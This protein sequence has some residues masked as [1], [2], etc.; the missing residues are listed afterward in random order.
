M[1]QFQKK[2]LFFS[3]IFFRIVA[4]EVTLLPQILQEYEQALQKLLMVQQKESG[5]HNQD[6]LSD[7]LILSTYKKL[8]MP[9][10]MWINGYARIV[11]SEMAYEFPYYQ[12]LNTLTLEY[13][14]HKTEVEKIIALLPAASQQQALDIFH[15][16][17]NNIVVQ[18]CFNIVQRLA[19]QNSVDDD[20]LQAAY[21]AYSLAW[22]I[23]TKKVKIEGAASFEEFE[24][25]MMSNMQTLFSSAIT[26]AQTLLSS[27]MS[28]GILVEPL[29]KKLQVCYQYLYQIYVQDG[30]ASNA[31]NQK[32]LLAALKAQEQSYAQAQKQQQQAAA[33]LQ[34]AYNPIV[35]DVNNV[36]TV[37]TSVADSITKLKSALLLY[38]AA[39]ESFTQ[40]NDI[41]GKSE[42]ERLQQRIGSGDMLLRAVQKLWG[43][44]LQDQSET[45]GV[46]T[47]PTLA[48]FVAG[49]ASGQ[50]VNA[51]QALQNLVGMC[52]DQYGDTNNVGPLFSSSYNALI[53]PILKNVS[54]FVEQNP[55]LTQ[56]IDSL[57]DFALIQDTQ[58]A[59]QVLLNLCNDMIQAS[60]ASDQT[61]IARAMSYAQLLDSLFIKND[62]LRQYV[63]YLPDSL[64]TG[65]KTWVNFT[66]QFFYQAGL[67]GSV[68][69]A[70]AMIGKVK[71]T[72]PVQLTAKDLE[73]MQN[74]ADNL[75]SQAEA[76]EK[77]ENFAS[78]SIAYE[79][80]MQLY[81]KLY[82]HE[83]DGMV[84]VKILTLANVAKTRFA[85][86]NFASVIQTDGSVTLG[87]L[88]NIPTSYR[89]KSY[90]FSFNPELTGGI[91]PA[92]L[93]NL[94]VG[95]TLTH[96][97][98]LDQADVFAFVKAT[99]V[100]QKLT[101]QGVLVEGGATFTDYFADYTMSKVVQASSRALTAQ[102]QIVKY[103]DNF[104]GM[105][106]NSVTLD[107]ANQVLINITNF[108]LEALTAPCTTLSSAGTYYAAASAL[109]A[110]GTVPLNLG[111]QTYDPGNDVLSANLML[112]NLGYV[113][114]S[115]AQALNVQ[116]LNLIQ[117]LS[118]ELG[119]TVKG[120]TVKTLPKDFT[121]KFASIQNTA[122]LMQ[123]LLY[124]TNAASGFFTQA[125]LISL[126]RK[127]K[128]EF[129]NVYKKQIDFSKNC[130]IGNPTSNEYQSIVTA[131]NRAYVSWA[132]ALDGSKDVSL[133]ANINTKI[134]ELYEF[135]G[136]QCLNYSYIEPEFPHFPQIHYMVAAQYYKSALLQYQ[137]LQ[138]ASK[139]E[140]LTKQVNGM[141]YQGCVQNLNLYLTV[142]K[143]GA[144]YKKTLTNS[145]VLITFDQ[146]ISD[147][148]DGSIGT[149]GET[150]LY[151]KIQDLLLD[152]A[153]VLD[154]LADNAGSLKK[155]TNIDS[156]T[157]VTKYQNANHKV[158]L[159]FL[160][161]QKLINSSKVQFFSQIP[162][163]VTEKIIKL[164]T[165][166]YTQF[167]SEP[168]I[169]AAW[170]NLLFMMVKNMYNMDYQAVNE[171]STSSQINLATQQ[172]LSSISNEAANLQNPS[173]GYIG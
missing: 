98:S 67:I 117:D 12:D 37:V 93:K 91:L 25:M 162:L 39:Q 129:L 132:A 149:D 107:S 10:V 77:A 26:Q 61:L 125:G 8:I 60:D 59:V 27:R 56:K 143:H 113:Y 127:I 72:L 87:Q 123:S 48:S 34:E 78:A 43:L 155:T 100:A 130:L 166:A 53:L 73:V 5:Q 89:A 167:F 75:F 81:Q 160:D 99:L 157:S 41:L 46:Y 28:S 115:A 163:G 94:V 139:V 131:I 128:Q 150:D 172:F 104:I 31:Q 84:Q 18:V 108:P 95:Q 6:V 63:P 136:Q 82:V 138:D 112:K 158:I 58:T 116:F 44:Y 153:M 122:I 2:I 9:S 7:P 45:Q 145:D 54:L 13:A 4:D 47:F 111:G 29:Y 57:L 16:F 68:A 50:L 19:N 71:V 120:A 121:K 118:Q 96:L 22:Q 62:S 97:S 23:K 168:L 142:K 40:A 110:V 156:S 55:N 106:I 119:I 146:L 154:F 90:Q 161:K 171:A 102:D 165:S 88:Q 133:V 140:E 11:F 141:Y 20:G 79:Q 1:K 38:Q 85:A 64:I 173:E 126:A 134:A 52:S 80:A 35:L 65:Q 105:Q 144:I 69:Q 33:E 103:L 21:Q 30:D 36:K 137:S 14:K 151:Q 76:L 32:N 51:V 66:A 92:C 114:L 147:F 15:E 124:G 17:L 101:D 49:K 74:K 169:F 164:A 135:A 70:Y 24:Q 170:N 86:T 42:C 109:F 148:N 159:Q 3:L 83:E 152:A